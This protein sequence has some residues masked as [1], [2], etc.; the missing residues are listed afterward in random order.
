MDKED[1]RLWLWR[2]FG[3]AVWR[4]ALPFGADV[5]LDICRLGFNPAIIFDVG[6]NVGQKSLYMLKLWPNADIHAFEPVSKTFQALRKNV[7]KRPQIHPWNIALSDSIGAAEIFL[8]TQYSELSSLNKP[9]GATSEMIQLTTLAAFTKDHEL[10]H[11]DLLKIDT[12]GHEESVLRGAG[13]MFETN[14]PS[15]CVI[16]AGF[17]GA[18]PFVPAD[19]LV[20]WFGDHGYRFAG[21]YDHGLNSKG[22]FLERADLLFIFGRETG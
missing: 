21:S 14:P 5:Y 19:T 10:D 2:K 22:R 3:L 7:A 12:E 16:E 11:V 17:N 8:D 1:V 4:H 20:K 6:A 18:K 9:G 15:I 13:A